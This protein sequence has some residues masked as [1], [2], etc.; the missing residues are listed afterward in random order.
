MAIVAPWQAPG[1]TALSFAQDEPRAP[2]V[3]TPLPIVEKM[4][5]LARVTANDV[6]YDLGSGDGRTVILAA[7]KFGAEAVGVELDDERFNES[8]AR[9]AALGLGRS[10]RILHANLFD[11]DLRRATV[12]T[13]YLLSRVSSTVRMGMLT[14]TPKVSVPQMTLS[15]PRCASCSTNMRYFGSSPA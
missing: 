7:Q 5:E 6:V 3:P 8:S 15:R 1:Q 4:L 10:A 13:L 11:A 9:I 14:P 12:V 2:F